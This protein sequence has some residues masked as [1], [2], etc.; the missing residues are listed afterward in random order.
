V[1]ALMTAAG[2]EDVRLD[3][4]NEMSWAAIGRKP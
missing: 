1:A 3:W 2:L 4:V